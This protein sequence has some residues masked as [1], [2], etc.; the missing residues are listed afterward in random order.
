MKYFCFFI[1]SLFL[2]A[3]CSTPE[4]K[5]DVVQERYIDMMVQA[6]VD[7]FKRAKIAT[8]INDATL[9]AIPKKDSILA[10]FA[11]RLAI[12]TLQR[13]Q[14]PKKP[15]RPTVEIQNIE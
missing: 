10:S 8:C 6:K 15:E 14:K 3:A 9:A 1:I 11:Q 4:S 7:S 2:W 13:P 12:D 5:M